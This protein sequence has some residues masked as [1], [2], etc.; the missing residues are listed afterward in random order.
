MMGAQPQRIF[1]LGG[2]GTIGRATIRALV[3]RGHHVV[4]FIRPQGRTDEPSGQDE[5]GSF[6][7]GVIIRYG[8]VTNAA[9]LMQDGLKAE[10]FDVLI[11]CLAS[12]TGAPEDAWA[13]NYSFPGHPAEGA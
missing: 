11:S 12:R 3:Q 2:T 7:A 13:D 4:C 8:D 10:R 6:P 5:R 9:S 1:V